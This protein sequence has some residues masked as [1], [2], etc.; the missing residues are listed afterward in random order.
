MKVKAK[1]VTQRVKPAPP[2]PPPPKKAAAKSGG[3]KAGGGGGGVGVRF[4]SNTLNL[5][6]QRPSEIEG[7]I[8]R[9][10]DKATKVGSLW[11]IH[12]HGTGAL[13]KRVRELLNEEP[14]V[15]RIADAPANEGGAGCTVAY[16]K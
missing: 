3:A 6:G 9:A 1:E 14:M 13:K 7:P 10:V 16:F 5:I 11:V 8:G 15:K 4:E 12:G 2:P